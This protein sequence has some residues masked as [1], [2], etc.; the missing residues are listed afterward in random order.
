MPG[1][2][3][4]MASI[5]VEGSFEEGTKMIVVFDPIGPGTEAAAG[6]D[7]PRRDHHAGGDIELN[8]GRR[9]DRAR[10]ASIPATAT[11]RCAATPTSSRSTGRCEFD[12]A[13]AFGMR[14][15]V[16]SGVGVRFEPGLRQTV[17]SRRASGDRAASS[18]RVGLCKGPLDAARG[19]GQALAL[20]RGR[21]TG[22][23]EGRW[24]RISREAHY[25]QMYGPTTGDLVR[26]GDTSF[27]PRSSTTSPSTA[28]S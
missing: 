20:A 28:T 5:S 26:L 14:L 1:V 19:Q 15:D 18:A 12:R 7:A 22:E 9:S 4:M 16:P 2:A 17:P 3:D 27:W 23:P 21:P 25:A 8:A 24:R 13:K 6:D 11:F 10:R